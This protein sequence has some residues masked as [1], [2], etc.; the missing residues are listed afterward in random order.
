[1]PGT[2]EALARD[3]V[4]FLDI[5]VNKTL[6]AY[7]K[8]THPLVGRRIAEW[9][10][11][12]PRDQLRALD[13]KTSEAV[14]YLFAYRGRRLGPDY[15]NG[16]LIPLLCRKAGIPDRDARGKITAH[17]ARATIASLLYNAK[18]PLP[19]YELMEYL[20]HK[21]LSST[22]H[23]A[24]VDRTKLASSVA[25]AG[26]LEQNLATIE[27]LLDQ[28]AVLSGAAAAGTPWK[29]YDL[30]HGYCTHTFWATC[31]HRM[32]C[33]RCP[34]Y[35]PKHP[36][37]E[38]LVEGQANLVQMLECVT[39]T[40]EERR[41]VE[42]GVALHQSLIEK[43]QDVPTPAGPTP[44][45]LG[46]AQDRGGVGSAPPDAPLG[47]IPREQIRRRSSVRSPRGP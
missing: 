5:P 10:L 3:A 22:Q 33:A 23:Y 2:G 38:L 16:T 39:L 41:L 18:E 25:K 28:E 19:L 30:G 27:V 31:Q 47:L 45:E 32:A 1:M 20:G 17:R 4:C 34:F 40:E 35:R 21:Q 42:E 7:A 37:A 24:R 13:A 8:P 6:T 14:H 36:T 46:G 29:Y 12:R 11:E 43:L 9:E 44:R 26:Y 15:L